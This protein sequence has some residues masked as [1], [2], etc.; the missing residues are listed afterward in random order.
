MGRVGNGVLTGYDSRFEAARL[1]SLGPVIGQ[2]GEKF[3]IK[4][5]KYTSEPLEMEVVE[6]FLPPPEELVLK[7]TRSKLPSG[8]SKPTVR[9]F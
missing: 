2:K 4:K 3:M 1:G 6:D 5:I 7:R 9:I 8:F